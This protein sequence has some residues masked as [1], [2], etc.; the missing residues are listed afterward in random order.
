[1]YPANSSSSASYAN[2]SSSA[3]LTGR[4]DIAA[5]QPDATGYLARLETWAASEENGAKAIAVIKSWL[6]K[7]SNTTILNLS[8]LGLQSLPPLPQGLEK[9][10]A[11][12]NRLSSVPENQLPASLKAIDIH[13]NQITA[14]PEALPITNLRLLNAAN[15]QIQSL[16]GGALIL[17]PDCKVYL[18]GNAIDESVLCKLYGPEL[19]A[20]GMRQYSSSSQAPR[21]ADA[22][23]ETAAKVRTL[24]DTL[25]MAELPQGFSIEELASKLPDVDAF[26]VLL[27]HLRDTASFQDPT[28]RQLLAQVTTQIVSDPELG[29]KA[30]S[31]AQELKHPLDMKSLQRYQVAYIFHKLRLHAIDREIV[32]GGFAG[33]SAD[34]V[35]HLRRKFRAQAVETETSGYLWPDLRGQQG[36]RNQITGSVMVKMSAAMDLAVDMTHVNDAKEFC[37]PEPLRTLSISSAVKN[38]EIREFTSYLAAHDSPAAILLKHANPQI[39]AIMNR[40]TDADGNLISGDAL[41]AMHLQDLKD[42]FVANG[43]PDPTLPV[44]KQNNNPGSFTFNGTGPNGAANFEIKEVP[45]CKTQ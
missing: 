24:A 19:N 10:M 36:Y 32:N 12:H 17:H 25:P 26:C 8:E 40:V 1:V 34:V 29:A 11:H 42:Y 14:L 33:R 22:G 6:A 38:Q 18:R 2:F 31:L 39:A 5:H 21:Q 9:L 4:A 30:C 43:I 13:N 35:R 3:G 20:T 28:F 27:K 41:T 15:N 16:S 37:D 44:W 45:T 7:G 23:R